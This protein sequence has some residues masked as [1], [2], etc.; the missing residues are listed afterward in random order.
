[1]QYLE[2]VLGHKKPSPIF[3]LFVNNK[4]ITPVAQN[5]NI[6]EGFYIINKMKIVLSIEAAIKNLLG[7]IMSLL[8]K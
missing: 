1:M 2:K 4:F 5:E 3:L 8:L 7:S 6:K